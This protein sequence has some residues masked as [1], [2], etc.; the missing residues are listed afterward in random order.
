MTKIVYIKT[1]NLELFIILFLTYK[2][3]NIMIQYI[4]YAN[5]YIFISSRMHVKTL[6]A[7]SVDDYVL[8]K[9]LKFNCAIN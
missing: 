6:K 8:L 9:T 4:K 5:I 3:R 1:N 2:K 7:S